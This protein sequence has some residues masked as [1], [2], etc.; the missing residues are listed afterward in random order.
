MKIL[1]VYK[2]AASL[3]S[4]Q[5][6][7]LGRPYIEHLSRVFL[8]VCERDGN[9]NQQV[10]ALLHDAIEDDKGTE[11]DLLQAGVPAAAV[12]LVMIL[13]KDQQQSY[14]EYVVGVKAYPE[15][16]LVKRCD[17]EDNSDPER[18]ALLDMETAERLR[19][20]YGQALKLLDD[21]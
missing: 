9:Y 19:T 11:S 12:A 13:T 1:D 3:H 18:L 2:L 21:A 15:A 6:D 14:P 20:K 7:K 17:L 8:R 4:G 5:T 10:A 16:A